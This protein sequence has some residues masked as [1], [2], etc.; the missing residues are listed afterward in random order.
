MAR[1]ILIDDDESILTMLR[2]CLTEEGHQVTMAQDGKSG[3]LLVSREKPNLIILDFNMPGLDGAMVHAALCKRSFTAG[4]P[5]I[6]LTA[7]PLI[8]VMPQIRN[9]PKT[10]FLQKPID[11]ALL[12]QT[13]AELLQ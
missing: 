1:I 8:E 11:L 7:A 5:I 13:I 4:V 12:T 3:L 6:L 10:R 2:L 9:D